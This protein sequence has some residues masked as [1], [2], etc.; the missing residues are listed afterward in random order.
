VGGAS[1]KA[2]ISAAVIEGNPTGAAHLSS[3]HSVQVWAALFLVLVSAYC[4]DEPA[5]PEGAAALAQ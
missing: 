2:S 5:N 3:Y 4:D 1:L